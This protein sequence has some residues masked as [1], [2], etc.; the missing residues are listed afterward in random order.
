MRDDNPA[1][2]ELIDL[3]S[4]ARLKEEFDRVGVDFWMKLTDSFPLLTQRAFNNML[5]PFVTTY[6]RESGFSTLVA[7][8]TKARNRLKAD[9]DMRVALSSTAP[10]INKLFDSMN[11]QSSH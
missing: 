7:M 5:V 11:Q 10:R 1:K 9:D 4:S 2:E 3:Q 6:L 8:K